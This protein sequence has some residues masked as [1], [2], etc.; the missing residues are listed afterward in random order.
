MA[1]ASQS[2]D[3]LLPPCTCQLQPHHMQPESMPLHGYEF[4]KQ[5]PVYAE[6]S[7]LLETENA[8]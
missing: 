5:V 3:R 2:L 8:F 4:A 1:A 6:Q 7:L